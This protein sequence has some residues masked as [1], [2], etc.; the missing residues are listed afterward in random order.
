MQRNNKA[1]IISTLDKFIA[2]FILIDGNVASANFGNDGV[3]QYAVNLMV[4]YM[5][6][7]DYKNAVATCNGDHLLILR[8]QLL[9]HFFS[10]KGYNKYA[11]EMLLNVVQCEILLS[12]A[13]A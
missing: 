7:V 10:A 12:E 1:Y 5:I 13:E 2:E 4:S 9:K 3:C 8:K 11:V 6:L